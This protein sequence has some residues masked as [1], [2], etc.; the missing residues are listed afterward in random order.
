MKNLMFVGA[1]YP[2]QPGVD[3]EVKRQFRNE[4]QAIMDTANM[5]ELLVIRGD[6]NARI[7]SDESIRR[8]YQSIC[9]NVI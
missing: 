9:S 6:M 7:E 3:G 2:P 1:L 8:M 5:R 4:I